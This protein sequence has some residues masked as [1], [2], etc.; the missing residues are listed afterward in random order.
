MA[1]EVL[2]LGNWSCDKTVVNHILAK[3]KY[4]EGKYKEG[5]GHSL[6]FQ[7]SSFLLSTQGQCQCF[8]V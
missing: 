1:A 7:R 2:V 5:N 6:F 8:L 4:K 3:E